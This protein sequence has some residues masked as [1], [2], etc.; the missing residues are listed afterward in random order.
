MCDQII[1]CLLYFI[2]QEKQRGKVKERLDKCVKE[3]LL[4]F[5]DVLNIPV[6]KSAAK[7]ACISNGSLST[8]SSTAANFIT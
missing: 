7:K 1:I 2:K 8:V 5:C 3:K 4:D 6:I